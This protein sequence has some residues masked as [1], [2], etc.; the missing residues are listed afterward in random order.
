MTGRYLRTI[1]LVL[2]IVGLLLVTIFVAAYI[3]SRIFSRAAIEDFR[4]LEN[5]PLPEKTAK[6]LADKQFNFDFSLWDNK[7]VVAYEESLKEH[8]A[9]P[10]AVLRISKV[11]L[12]VPVLSGTDDLTLN[13]GVGLINGTHRP[14]EGGNIGIAGHRDGFFRVLKDV[15][16]GDMIELETL[17]R[18]DIYRVSQIVIVDPD[19]VSVLQPTSA[20]TLTLVTCYPFYFIGSAPKRYIVEASLVTSGRP[21]AIE[22]RQKTSSAHFAPELHNSNAQSQEST[23]EITQ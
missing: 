8:F 6:S 5:Q 3:H 2:L 11:D 7:R 13:R 15:G 17:D 4:A 20:P 9:P 12:E 16:P 18:I 22:Q 19:D 21:A 23:K 10:V 1:E 14:G